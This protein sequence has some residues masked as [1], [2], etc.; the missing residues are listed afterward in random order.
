MPK[1]LILC[2]WDWRDW[3][4]YTPGGSGRWGD[5]EIAVGRP[6]PCDHLVVINDVQQ[7]VR[8]R[9]PPENVWLAPAEPPNEVY[10]SLHDHRPPF[11][12]VLTQSETRTGG[13]YVQAPTPTAWTVLR[14][15]DWLH[16]CAVPRKTRRLSWITSD[17][18]DFVGHRRR[19]AFHDQARRQL[20][21]D[22]F[23]RGIQ[24]VDDKWDAHAPYRYALVV[25]NFR[26]PYYW[27]EKIIDALMAWSMPIYDGC[28]R[29]HEMIPR[30]AVVPI[31]ID[32]PSA[33]EE[34]REVAASDRWERNLDAIAEARRRIL[35]GLQIFPHLERMLREHAVSERPSRPR[36][37]VIHPRRYVR[38]NLRNAL[39]EFLPRSV[40]NRLRA[41]IGPR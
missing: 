24:P 18:R 38:R 21:C 32:S 22:F 41:M 19:M 10:A 20:D 34:I 11:T 31:N 14:D 28:T 25:E 6:Q 37:V 27:S 29:I 33:L 40:K 35:D 9:C 26:G 5:L 7:K 4:R 15:Y 2:D 8:A 39:A 23:G 17:K 12:R 1:L 30:E 36:G 3:R 16:D 13:P